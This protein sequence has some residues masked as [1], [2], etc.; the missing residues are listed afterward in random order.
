MYYDENRTKINEIRFNLAFEV[1]VTVKYRDIETAN[2]GILGGETS[3]HH[4][5][6]ICCAIFQ[7]NVDRVQDPSL[8]QAV[9]LNQLR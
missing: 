5:G 3:F 2:F 4:I 1:T 9:D 8:V 7:E 6:I